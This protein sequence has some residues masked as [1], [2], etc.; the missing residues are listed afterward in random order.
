MPLA[1]QAVLAIMLRKTRENKAIKQKEK[2][3]ELALRDGRRKFWRWYNPI[4]SEIKLNMKNAIDWYFFYKAKDDGD[5]SF[6]LIMWAIV[7]VGLV[8]WWRIAFGI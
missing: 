3:W 4:K 1:S 7:T 5:K 2:E 8:G 6:H